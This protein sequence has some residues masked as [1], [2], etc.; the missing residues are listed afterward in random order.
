ML[1]LPADLLD[2]GAKLLGRAGNGGDVGAGFLGRA[3]HRGR[4]GRGL[5]GGS[6]ELRGGRLHLGRGGGDHVD[7]AAHGLF[8]A[9]GEVAHHGLLLFRLGGLG[10]L[11]LGAHALV[12]AKGVAET[13]EGARLVTDL[14][15]RRRVGN[16]GVEIT[17]GDPLHG[18]RDAHQ[19]PGHGEN[20]ECD[21]QRAHNAAAQNKGDQE[22]P[23]ML[24]SCNAP[25]ELLVRANLVDVDERRSVPPHGLDSCRE[26]PAI[27]GL[28]LVIRRP[29]RQ[30]DHPP[31]MIVEGRERFRE[32][33]IAGSLLIAG[34]KRLVLPPQGRELVQ[35]C[36]DLLFD[37]RDPR[38]RA[39]KDVL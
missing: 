4:L 10:G 14:V 29:T 3:R 17:L 31:V 2:R 26:V 7:D 37:R 30:V 34:N 20:D 32:A 15:R 36:V 16:V 6:G 33:L 19:G 13:D 28:R 39:R 27:E 8:E 25:G 24:V 18:I 21:C 22:Q 35:S 1:D 12:L 9:V 23:R 5:L 38:R 11:L